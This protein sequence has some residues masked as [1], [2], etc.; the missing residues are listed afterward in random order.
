MKLEM[1]LIPIVVSRLV[2]V[3]VKIPAPTNFNTDLLSGGEHGIGN[4]FPTRKHF[5]VFPVRKRVRDNV[6]SARRHLIV[7]R[8]RKRNLRRFC[9][10]RRVLSG[11]IP[12]PTNYREILRALSECNF[13]DLY[14]QRVNILKVPLGSRTEYAGHGALPEWRL[15]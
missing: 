4:S 10:Y 15:R 5:R 7:G 11:L 1:R 6:D 3:A 13:S 12:M 2:A 9:P 8:I 14:Q